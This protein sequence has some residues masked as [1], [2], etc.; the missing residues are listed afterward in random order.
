MPS[1]LIAI[2]R[3]VPPEEEVALMDAVHGALQDAFKPSPSSGGCSARAA[4]RQFRGLPCSTRTTFGRR[5]FLQRLA[6]AAG[7]DPRER[8]ESWFQYTHRF[9]KPG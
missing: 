8:F 3:T 4:R 5:S 6:I 2:R 1:V 9:A 7:F